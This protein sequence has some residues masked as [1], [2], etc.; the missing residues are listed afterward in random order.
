MILEDS[1]VPFLINN[2]LS[3]SQYLL[4]HLIYK[5][6]LHLIKKYKEAFPSGD[7]NMIGE[8]FTKDLFNR[9]FL[10]TKFINNKDVVVVTDKFLN[11]FLDKNKATD[12]IYEIYPNFNIN[13]DNLKTMDRNI[14]AKI[15]GDFI[16]DSVEEHLEIKKDIEFGIINNII[17][18]DIEKFI[19]SKYWLVLRKLRNDENLKINKTSIEEITKTF[20]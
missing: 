2:N 6:K 15:Y 9:G 13:N 14:F 16:F 12:E 17:N 20:I 19:K 7:N 8:Y 18:I 11:I 3:Q 4:L 10:T 5:Q 1:Y